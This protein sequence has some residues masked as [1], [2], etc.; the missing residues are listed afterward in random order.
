VHVKEDII[1]RTELLKFIYNNRIIDNK[2]Y[3]NFNVAKDIIQDKIE[4]IVKIILIRYNKNT[5]P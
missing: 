2:T 4:E 5:I 3:D 1:F